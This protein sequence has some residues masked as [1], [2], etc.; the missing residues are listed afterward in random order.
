[1]HDA[2]LAVQLY[3]KGSLTD[4]TDRI[5]RVIE[6]L[7]PLDHAEATATMLLIKAGLCARSG[8]IDAG[9]ALLAQVQATYG[10]LPDKFFQ[11]RIRRTSNVIDTVAAAA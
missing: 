6:K 11:A 8:D 4:K 7:R 3:L 5:D 2:N 9:R 1:V 10:D